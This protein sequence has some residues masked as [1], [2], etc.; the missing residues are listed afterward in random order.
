M[1]RRQILLNS[2]CL[3]LFSFATISHP[4]AWAE[5]NVPTPNVWTPKTKSVS[6]FKNGLAFFLQEGTAELHDGWCH[7]KSVPPAA[8]GTFA[9]FSTNSDHQVNLVGIG[10]GDSIEFETTNGD[11]GAFTNEYE[12]KIEALKRSIGL[13][14]KLSYE[15]KGAEAEAMGKLLDVTGAH[16]L[17]ET[18]EQT[19]AVALKKLKSV[20]LHEHPVRIKVTQEGASIERTQLGM[21]YL[22]QGLTWIPEYTIK[23]IDEDTAEMTLRATLVNEAEDLIDCNVNFI[24]GVPNFMHNEILSPMVAGRTLRMLGSTHSNSSAPPQVMSQMMN[25]AVISN[26]RLGMMNGMV[27]N[28]NSAGAPIANDPAYDPSTLNSLLT[29]QPATESA[30]AGDYT[31]YQHENLTLRKGERAMVTLMSHTV[32]YRHRYDWDGVGSVQHKLLLSNSTSTPWTTGSCLTMT[33]AQP[34]SEDILKYT[35]VGGQG[36]LAITTAINLAKEAQEHEIDRRFKAHEPR[37]NEFFDLVTI[38][39]AITVKSFEK[40]PVELVIS[41]AVTGKPITCSHDGI[42]RSDASKL[43]LV[44]REGMIDWSVKLNPGEE[45]KL[46]YTYE[47]YVPSY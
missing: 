27:N 29:N 1:K 24:V 4:F 36:E 6:V 18:S 11:S 16:V 35:P 38:Q 47:R 7:A 46:V 15:T 2:V 34:L 14:M 44:E 25:R 22:R 3:S 33:S 20:S 32:K 28:Y 21:A 26:D 12:K 17:L 31:V 30:G 5:T 42:L 41:K 23:L 40:Q 13:N 19:L 37:S 9:V 43:R 39:G 45:V 10:D 8:F